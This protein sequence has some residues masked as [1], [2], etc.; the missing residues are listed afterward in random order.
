MKIIKKYWKYFVLG[1]LS[2]LGL[3]RIVNKYVKQRS[4]E[5]KRKTI[6]ENELEI[7]KL[8]GKKDVTETQKAELVKKIEKEKAA[9][10]KLKE[11]LATGPDI[12]SSEK[13]DDEIRDNILKHIG[14]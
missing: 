11:E 3:F 12:N 4:I 7:S 8:Q 13:T 14:K 9:L 5:R 1:L 2:I 6:R 10:E